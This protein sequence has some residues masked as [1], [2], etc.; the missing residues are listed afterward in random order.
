[1]VPTGGL[2]RG[3]SVLGHLEA[4][5]DRVADQV[6]ERRLEPVEDVAVDAGGLADDLE[7][8]LLA[9]LPGH[10]ADQRAGNRERR[11]PAAASGWPAL[12]GAAD[13][14]GFH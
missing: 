2:P 13:W 6:I 5:V 8:C 1:M 12:R 4:V 11:Q 3:V 10:V 9:E 7:P 14:K